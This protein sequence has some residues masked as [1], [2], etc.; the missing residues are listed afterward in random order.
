MTLDLSTQANIHAR[1]RLPTPGDAVLGVAP[2]IVMEPG[3]L[4]EVSEVLAWATRKGLKVTPCGS[5]TKLDRGT[6]PGR[7]DVLLDLSR[8]NRVMEHA[9]G[10]LTV[11]VQAGTGLAGLQRQLAGAGQCLAVDPPV[12]GTVGG[13]IATADTGPRRLRYG[14]VRDLIL[15]ATFV[16]ADGVI[17][18]AGGKVVKNVAGYDLPKLLTG[19]LGTLAVVVEATFRLYPL[20]AAS[21][22]VIADIAPADL[23]RCVCAILQSTLVPTSLDYFATSEGPSSLAIRFESTTAST[24][25]QAH[26]AARLMGA[27]SRIV[28]G[29][30]E[31]TLWQRFDT[32]TDTA[33]NDVLGRLVATVS[34]LPGLLDKALRAT[35]A[36]TTL[37][38][39]AHAGHGH[40]LL[41]WHGADSNTA[42]AL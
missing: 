12:P 24:Q 14:G 7:V 35:S 21:A 6:T 40:A 1:S 9:S 11:T 19:S 25:A 2:G 38:V 8:L 42:G 18:K 15:G 16:R 3:N 28:T 37:T 20:P 33:E 39:R 31:Q 10:D 34:D 23:R 30:E 13:L 4:E 41:K 17:A 29:V 26:V 27:S 32:V 22:T 5:R 36:G